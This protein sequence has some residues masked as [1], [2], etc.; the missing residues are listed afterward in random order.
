MSEPLGKTSIFSISRPAVFHFLSCQ[1]LAGIFSVHLHHVYQRAVWKL[2]DKNFPS[3]TVLR[4]QQ[5][6]WIVASSHPSA[7]QPAAVQPGRLFQVL[8]ALPCWPQLPWIPAHDD[9]MG[10]CLEQMYIYRC[11]WVTANSYISYCAAATMHSELPSIFPFPKILFY[12]TRQ[13]QNWI[14]LLYFASIMQFLLPS[15]I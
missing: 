13:S 3:V 7:V 4:M 11:R 15:L 8:T 5:V 10:I 12:L 14:R 2:V 9:S 6:C 1:T